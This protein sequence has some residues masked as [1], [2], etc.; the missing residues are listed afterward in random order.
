[1]LQEKQNKEFLIRYFNAMST[2]PEL[3]ETLLKEYI[4]DEQLIAHILFFNSVFPNYEIYTEQIIAEG[5]KVVVKGSM[6]GRH[7]GT[8][9]GIPPTH[10]KVDFPLVICYQ[11]ENE[12]IVQH[13][14]IADQMKLLEQLGVMNTVQE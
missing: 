11:I 5:N 6:R 8:L 13:W 12:K 1:M 2:A 14:L 10:K 9:N 4:T 7:E 3:T